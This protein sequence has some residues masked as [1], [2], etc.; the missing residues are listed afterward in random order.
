M[1]RA[2]DSVTFM[3]KKYFNYMYEYVYITQNMHANDMLC[4]LEFTFRNNYCS[5]SNMCRNIIEI[6]YID[7]SR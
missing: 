5:N 1:I 4:S 2:N 6:K 7:E 3:R